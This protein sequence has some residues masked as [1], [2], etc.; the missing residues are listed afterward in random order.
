MDKH[1]IANLTSGAPET[2]PSWFKPNV[3]PGP[4]VPKGHPHTGNDQLDKFLVNW[5]NDPCWDLDVYD[6]KQFSFPVTYEQKLKAIKYVD[7]WETYWRRQRVYV[8][9]RERETF[10]QWRIFYASDLARRICV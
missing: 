10:L 3:R 4:I 9:Q 6:P 5:H 8:R 1:M 2:I 7:E